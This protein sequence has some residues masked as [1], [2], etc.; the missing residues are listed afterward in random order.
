MA[1]LGVVHTPPAPAPIDVTQLLARLLREPGRPRITWYGGGGERVE[2]SGAVLVNWVSK[3]ANLLVEEFD[4]APGARVLLDLPAHWRA[5]VWALGT[6]RTGACVVPA[7]PAGAAVDEGTADV[8]VTSRP[9]AH[10]GAD[11]VAVALPALARRFDASLPPGAIDA[12]AA[13]MTYG[14]VVGWAP[15]TDPGAPALPGAT[16][17]GLF[18]GLVPAL[19]GDD[20]GARVLRRVDTGPV[21]AAVLRDWLG[22]LAL[23]GSLVVVRDGADVDV[24]RVVSDERVSPRG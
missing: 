18:S 6:W 21:P 3:T 11:V 19:G 9:E 14:D 8:V 23:D 13:V 16:F 20:P 5:L 2:L 7:D 4:A 1:S 10:P 22:V 12:A 17:S 15:E 24:D